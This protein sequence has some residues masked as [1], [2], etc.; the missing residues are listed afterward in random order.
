M[1][2][3]NLSKELMRKQ[4]ENNK[5]PAWLLTELAARKGRELAKK[6]NVEERLV[7]SSLYLAHTVFSPVWH[8]RIR[9]NHPKL[10]AEFAERHLKKWGV[11]EKEQKIII[12]S[13]LHHPD[14]AKPKT[15]MAEVVKNAECFKFVTVKGS[16]IW[17]HECGRRGYSFEDSVKK[18]LAKMQEKRV[19]LTLPDCME[20]AEKE[21]K[22]IEKI[23]S[24]K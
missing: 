18:V 6:H 23:F 14:K 8:D 24:E 5:A 15:K 16:L 22:M 9:R 12:D 13:I 11:A 19:L 20:D 1:D 17:L 3:I 7:V 10:S 21:C 2:L 4:T